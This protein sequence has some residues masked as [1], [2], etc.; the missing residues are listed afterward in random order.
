MKQRAFTLIEL[1]IV[2]AIM[3]VVLV[4]TGYLAIRG[5]QS[6]TALSIQA[7]SKAECQRAAETVFR[8]AAA[9][10]GYTLENNH[11]GIA[12]RDGSR[13]RWRG[14]RLELTQ[15]GQT[16][17]LLS[18]S[19]RDFTA[20]ARNGILTLNLSVEGQRRVRGAVIRLHEIYDYPRVGLP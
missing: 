15:R 8:L 13:V 18:D 1:M 16:R 5:Y 17:S 14:D 11:H 9:N 2:L 6:F 3:T 4:P 7:S 20:I 10:G 19:V 12:F